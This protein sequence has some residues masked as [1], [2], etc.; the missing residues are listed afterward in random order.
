MVST[1]K[2]KKHSNDSII[3]DEYD[4]REDSFANLHLPP[5]QG[6]DKDV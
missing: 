3:L 6:G 2:A 4:K 5:F 1:S